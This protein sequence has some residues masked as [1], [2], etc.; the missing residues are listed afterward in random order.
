M[1]DYSDVESLVLSVIKDELSD[2]EYDFINVIMDSTKSCG[3]GFTE[4]DEGPFGLFKPRQLVVGVDGFD[5]QDSFILYKLLKTVY[6]ECRHI[7]QLC[8]VY[9]SRQDY[10]KSVDSVDLNVFFVFMSVLSRLYSEQYYRDNYYINFCE[11]DAEYHALIKTYT[12]FL[13]KYGSLADDDFYSCVK[14]DMSHKAS[15]FFS[16]F[17]CFSVSDFIGKSR[18]FVFDS[19]TVKRN[20]NSLPLDVQK[21]L[22]Y[23]T[24][25]IVQDRYLSDIV[26]SKDSFL[27]DDLFC[28][29]VISDDLVSILAKNLDI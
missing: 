9:K 10:L 27:S 8:H 17:G 1:I 19:V 13:K 5:L 14:H 12:F 20:V 16:V 22:R 7:E 23:V 25:G 28:K 3:R 26:I 29:R 4:T 24:K 18:D 15:Y 2:Y 6:H 21:N 11:I